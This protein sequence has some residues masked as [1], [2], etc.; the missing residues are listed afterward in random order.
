[1]LVEVQ[2]MNV[3]YGELHVILLTNCVHLCVL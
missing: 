2:Y 3:I 1:M